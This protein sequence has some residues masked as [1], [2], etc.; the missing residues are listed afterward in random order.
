MARKHSKESW[1]AKRG[2]KEAAEHEADRY[3]WVRVAQ[4]LRQ[5]ANDLKRSMLTAKARGGAV[6]NNPNE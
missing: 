2:S 4:T 6:T 3:R 5:C 1:A